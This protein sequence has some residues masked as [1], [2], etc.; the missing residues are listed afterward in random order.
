M[1]TYVG[2]AFQNQISGTG[3]AMKK[4]RVL[5]T[6]F[7][8]ARCSDTIRYQDDVWII[9]Q[10]EEHGGLVKVNTGCAARYNSPNGQRSIG[11][12]RERYNSFAT[13]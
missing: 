9:D 12:P 13:T 2:W 8:N 6:L 1:T 4:T 7:L 10:S 3:F 5:T 11:R